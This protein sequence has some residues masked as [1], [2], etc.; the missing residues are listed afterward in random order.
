MSRAA[1][2][3]LVVVAAL[4]LAA[5]SPAAE[6]P[7]SL[8]RLYAYDRAAP[9]DV[10][11]GDRTEAGGVTVQ[12]LSFASPKGGRVTAFLVVPPGAG[13]FPAV[14]VSPGLFGTAEDSLFDARRRAG[15]GVA[16]LLIDPPHTRRD[17]PRLIRCTSAD[18]QPYLQYVVE[19]RRAVD[20]LA[21]RPEIDATRIGHAGFSYG[22]VIGGTLAGV[23]RRI[24]AFAITSGRGYWSKTLRDECHQLSKAKRAA[25]VRSVSVLDPMRYV[26][27]A[28]PSALLIQNGT[29]DPFAPRAEVEAMRKRASRPSTVRLYRLGHNLSPAAFAEREAWLRAQLGASGVG[30]A[31]RAVVSPDVPPHEELVRLFDYDAGVPL[32]V[33]T[34]KVTKRT[35]AL[36]RDISYASPKGGRVTA[37]L[38]TPARKGRFPAVLFLHGHPGGRAS[39][40]AEALELARR[41]VVSLLPDSPFVRSPRPP[42]VSFSSRDREL[43]VQTVVELR[44][45]VDV[46]SA[47]GEVERGRIGFVGS[48]FGASMGGVLAGVERRITAYVLAGALFSRVD[49][50]SSQHPEA[51]SA[52]AQVSSEQWERFLASVA[53]LDAVHYLPHAAPSAL[54]LQLSRRDDVTPE[55]DAAR[56]ANAAS[57]PKI[58]R[59]RATAALAPGRQE[60]RAWLLYQLGRPLPL[61]ESCVSAAERSGTHRFRA[62]DGTR[63][64]G[65]RLGS[66]PAGVVL[67]HTRGL[68]LCSWLPYAR[69]L[70]ASGLHVLAIDARGQGSSSDAFTGPE[71][72][73]RDLDF[74]GAVAELRRLGATSVVLAG[75]SM[76]GTSALGAAAAV[77]LPVAG[78]VSL[79]GPSTFGGIDGL[80]AVAR[81]R[82]PVLFVAAAQDAQFAEDAVLLH[83]RAAAPDKRLVIVPG[84]A[85]GTEMLAERSVHDLVLAF[86]RER[87]SH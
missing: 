26:A 7:A 20:V 25:Y 59:W 64:L 67:M 37:Y 30:T 35:G 63:L 69:E 24:K 36:V 77:D 47:R 23:E 55:A 33:R 15:N 46:L 38:V 73:R 16:S 53:P 19:L 75:S 86:I 72:T 87:L 85:H 28:S 42:L 2:L 1:G 81:L 10:R 79:S 8:A 70:G 66:G 14:L 56:Y 61:R 31:R 74:V 13:P 48:A 41:G 71:A 58:V 34:S 45:G 83:E 44:R 50:W 51:V 21:A 29:R 80:A 9:L 54:L 12:A 32:A 11:L 57:T 6:L 5:P 52:R 76:G 4:L 40:L 27:Y 68:D 43:L 17:G 3:L 65:V 60:R 49:Y 62:S 18:R 82:A 78:V 22:A 39:F 84:G